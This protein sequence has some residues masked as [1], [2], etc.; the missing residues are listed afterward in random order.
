MRRNYKAFT[1]I[2]I[3]IIIAV[4]ATLMVIVAFRYT[5]S[6]SRARTLEN[7]KRAQDVTIAVEQF[8]IFNQSSEAHYPVK[9]VGGGFVDADKLFVESLPDSVKQVLSTTEAPNGSHTQRIYYINCKDLTTNY[10]VGIKVAFWNYD[11]NEVETISTGSTDKD[12][13]V[14]CE[15]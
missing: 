3:L 11:K 14:R 1:L 12:L 8:L 6:Q 5:S 2:E 4:L 13:N 15:Y 10:V 7:K 9:K